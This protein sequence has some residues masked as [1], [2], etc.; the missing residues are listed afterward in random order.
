M[1]WPMHK[2][3]QWEFA[4][5][6]KL[7][8]WLIAWYNLYHI[9]ERAILSPFLS[10]FNNIYSLYYK[11]S[12]NNVMFIYI[13]NI[14]KLYFGPLKIFLILRKP[15]V[16]RGT[17]DWKNHFF[18]NLRH[19]NFVNIYFSTSNKSSCKNLLDQQSQ[20]NHDSFSRNHRFDNEI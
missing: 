6:F 15:V 16:G 14:F 5:E 1:V 18:F 12:K 20:F 10:W 4:C 11:S 8:R 13:F 9:Y 17:P 3:W 7:V 19:E 2:L